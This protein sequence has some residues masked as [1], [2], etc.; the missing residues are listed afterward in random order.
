M[1]SYPVDDKGNPII[2][3]GFD[4][5]TGT[6]YAFGDPAN[7]RDDM[8]N[9]ITYPTLPDGREIRTTFDII[10]VVSEILANVSTLAER[11]N[12]F[13]DVV[14]QAKAISKVAVDN[15]HLRV[16]ELIERME[17]RDD[18]PAVTAA[19]EWQEKEQERRENALYIQK[20]L[21]VAMLKDRPNTYLSDPTEYVLENANELY[22]WVRSGL[23][24][25][26]RREWEEEEAALNDDKASV[27]VEEAEQQPNPQPI[28]VQTMVNR[29][30]RWKLPKNFRPDNGISFTP[31]FSAEPMRSQQWPSGTN[32]FDAKQAEEMVL[33]MLGVEAGEA[34][35]AE[36]E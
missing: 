28:D 27:P 24:P 26:Q 14:E 15:M 35:T 32:L 18:A 9:R 8:V 30:L 22:L 20:D 29:F 7:T 25:K 19:N 17:P 1:A 13:A 16:D 10:K 34:A 31:T 33:H 4:T 36:A 12:G 21:V 6:P 5:S 23:T 3:T 2:Q 11:M